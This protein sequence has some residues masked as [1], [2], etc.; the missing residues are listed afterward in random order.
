VVGLELVEGVGLNRGRGDL[1]G[2][3]DGRGVGVGTFAISS[4]C[5]GSARRTSGS[6]DEGA[7]T[8]G[9]AVGISVGTGVGAGVTGIG[10][11]LSAG[12]AWGAT[13]RSEMLAVAMGELPGA[14]V[15]LGLRRCICI[16]HFMAVNPM[17][18]TSTPITKGRSDPRLLLLVLRLR[19]TTGRLG[20]GSGASCK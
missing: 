6:A 11:E 9:V 19:T 17:T 10:V 2:E 1:R 12:W 16:T 13:M 18:R 3:E 4:G 14:G 15:G 20:S 5:T 8:N 7:G